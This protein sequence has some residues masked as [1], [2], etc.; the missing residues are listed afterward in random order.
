M[1]DW[2]EEKYGLNKLIN[3]AG[4]DSDSDGKSNLNEYLAGTDPIRPAG[5]PEFQSTSLVVCADSVNAL[6]LMTTDGDTPPAQLVYTVKTAP[7]GLKRRVAR[8]GTATP[9]EPVSAG[10]TFTQADVN[11]GRILFSHADGAALNA[12]KISLEVTD[13]TTK[14]ASTVTVRFYRPELSGARSF[15]ANFAAAGATV[16]GIATVE[17]L[18]AKVYLLASEKQFIA[19]DLSGLKAGTTV[20]AA[21]ATSAFAMLGTTGHDQMTG[22]TGAD[23]LAGGKGDDMLTGGAGADRFV[24]NVAAEGNDTITDF[25]VAGGDVIDLSGALSGTATDLRQYVRLTGSTISLDC[26]GDG[27]GFT[28]ATITLAGAPAASLFSLF[29]QGALMAA[30][31]TLPAVITITA[32][33][34]EARENGPV[35]AV[36]ALSRLGPVDAPLTVAVSIAGSAT[37]GQDYEPI[38]TSVLIPAGQKSAEFSVLP[39]RDSITEPRETIQISVQ[40]GAG[41]VVEGTAAATAF[42][43]D[44]LPEIQIEALEPLAVVK[45]LEPGVFAIH[46]SAATDRNTLVRLSVSGN[47]TPGVD[48]A[49]LPAYVNF[50]ANQTLALVSVT[51]LATAKLDRDA[52]S[53]ILSLT[54]DSGYVSGASDKAKVMIV[55]RRTS[56]TEWQGTSAPADSTQLRVASAESPAA[57]NLLY[58]AFVMDPKDPKTFANMPDAKMVDGC[59]AIEFTKAWAATDIRYVIEVSDDMKAWRS[60]SADAAEVPGWD[61]PSDARAVLWRSLKPAADSGRQFMRVRIE[62][63]R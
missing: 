34:P 36:F 6:G 32:V 7:A 20:A 1:P 4:G 53:V 55:P 37:Y 63:I 56:A 50:A 9:D 21:D 3:D 38:A 14:V 57:S 29:H 41:Y 48:Y 28:D 43:N 40:P 11:A 59:L 42:I 49:R 24:F 25:D 61:S 31:K 17:Q 22:G 10:K 26:N 13:D 52:E 39:Y 60:S 44:L 33:Q 62:T 35:P 19:W 5:Q 23:W 30:G 27:S 12:V 8:A 16:P 47:A 46:R 18:R 15:L 45:G 2:W 58:Y 51:P 54:A